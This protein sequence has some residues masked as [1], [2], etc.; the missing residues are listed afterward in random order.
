MEEG[1]TPENPN[2]R[3]Q[4][5][6][7]PDWLRPIFYLSRYLGE[8]PAEYVAGV[9]GGE[10]RFFFPSPEDIRRNYNYN[11]NQVLVEA[12]RKGYRG[13]FWDILRRLAEGE[14]AG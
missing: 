7:N 9:I 4:V 11:E 1:F 3:G 8:N 13:A 12:I 6:D 14:G 2:L 10:G 5:E